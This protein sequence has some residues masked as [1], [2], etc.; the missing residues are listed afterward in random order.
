MKRYCKEPVFLFIFFN[1][2]SLQQ[3]FETIHYQQFELTLNESNSRK[4]ESIKTSAQLSALS[5]FETR[6]DK[7]IAVFSVA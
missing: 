6:W 1:L 5:Y 7:M 2:K 3:S 4:H